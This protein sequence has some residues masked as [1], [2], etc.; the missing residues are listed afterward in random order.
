[1]TARQPPGEK[2]AK[3]CTIGNT[4]PASWIFCTYFPGVREIGQI[5]MRDGGEKMFGAI[6]GDIAGS[7]FEFDNCKSKEFEL[8]TNTCDFTDDTVMTLAV[9]KALL[10][11]EAITDMDTFK[12]EL[13]RVMHEVGMPHPHCGYGG[14]F[15]TWMMKNDIEPYGSYG[16]GS[17]MRV[18]PVAWFAGSLG[19]CERL[20]AAT[21]EVTHNHPE[22]IKGAVVVAGAIYLARTGHSMA[23]IREYTEQYYHIDFTLDEIRPDYDFVETCQGSV[24]QALEAFF[25]SAG[26]ED[27]IR[28]A[29]SI[30][31]DSDTI[32]DMA[33]AIAEAYYGADW[34]MKD[35]A[36]SYLDLDLLDIAEE[37]E[38]RIMRPKM[39]R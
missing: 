37:F 20:A 29:V 6:I 23:E 21:A 9:A 36:L 3:A 27:A 25:E 38:R 1:M 35:I 17:A 19:E 4:S 32:A 39:P 7:R 18:S 5:F 34:E 2:G 13:V 24:P 16:N 30:G 11:Y 22:G 15:C 33:G 28:N 31:G 14:R 12:R 8:F 10:P 26:F